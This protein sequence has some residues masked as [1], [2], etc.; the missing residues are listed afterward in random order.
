MV[1]GW[2]WKGAAG[3]AGLEQGERGGRS[4]DGLGTTMEGSGRDGMRLVRAAGDG[5]CWAKMA[6]EDREEAGEA[7]RKWS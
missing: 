1:R 4:G 6:G 7:G 2:A 3:Q 5:I